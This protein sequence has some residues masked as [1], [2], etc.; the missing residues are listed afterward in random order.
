MYIG[1]SMKNNIKKICSLVLVC[2]LIITIV[3]SSA[4]A[5]SYNDISRKF[6]GYGVSVSKY[7]NITITT[8][9]VS[10]LTNNKSYAV[11]K[12]D[13]VTAS[14]NITFSS[15]CSSQITASIGVKDGIVTGDLGAAIEAK[16]DFS[17]SY[18]RTYTTSVSATV[19]AK[20]TYTV[21]AQIKGD[22]VEVYYKYFVAYVTTSK[23]DG[24]V[25]VP[26]YVNWIVC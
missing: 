16:Y 23:G 9:T 4:Q 20:S 10:Q 2:A 26:K 11:T 5:A 1:G 7:S 15:G 21:K 13:T 3:P 6:Y 24:K 8:N 18:T 12:T 14:R 25:Y 17:S 19:P 22:K